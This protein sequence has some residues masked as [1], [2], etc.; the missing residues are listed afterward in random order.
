M[1][2]YF[3]V[4]S[5]FICLGYI[6]FQWIWVHQLASITC[7]SVYFTTQSTLK[8]FLYINIILANFVNCNMYLSYIVFLG[9]LRIP[10]FILKCMA[11]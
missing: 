6:T 9:A 7:L 2:N 4:L 10:N 5:Q 3:I 11:T 1:Q 8:F